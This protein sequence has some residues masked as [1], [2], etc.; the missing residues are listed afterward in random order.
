MKTTNGPAPAKKAPLTHADLVDMFPILKGE[1]AGFQKDAPPC[2]IDPGAFISACYSHGSGAVK[3]AA[4][5]CQLAGIALRSWAP[6]V[7]DVT[8]HDALAGVDSIHRK[9]F[10]RAFLAVFERGIK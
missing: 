1:R 6:I 3:C 10:K 2:I 4:M 8:I 9:A 5:V 7:S